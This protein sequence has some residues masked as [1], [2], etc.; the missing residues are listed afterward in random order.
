[1]ALPFLHEREVPMEAFQVLVV[2]GKGLVQLGPTHDRAVGEKGCP[3]SIKVDLREAANGHQGPAGHL[4][5]A[6][7]PD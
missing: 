1:M 7:A 3:A 6:A 2:I 5:R 4:G